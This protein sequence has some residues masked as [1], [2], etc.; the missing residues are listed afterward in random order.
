MAYIVT[1][2]FASRSKKSATGS[3]EGIPCN[4]FDKSVHRGILAHRLEIPEID[5]ISRKLELRKTRY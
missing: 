3:L 4:G 1:K 2:D 5:P